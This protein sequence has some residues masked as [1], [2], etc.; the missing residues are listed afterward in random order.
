MAYDSKYN[1]VALSEQPG[2]VGYP[3]HRDFNT[4]LRSPPRDD[5]TRIGAINHQSERRVHA[6]GK[7]RWDEPISTW[8]QHTGWD[9]Y[10]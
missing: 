10:P 6:S 4:G 9:V 8:A 5:A 7:C 2:D 1:T 3:Y